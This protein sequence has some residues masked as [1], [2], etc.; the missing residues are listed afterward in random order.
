[1]R[2]AVVGAGEFGRNHAR[3]Y[4]EIPGAELVGIYD[5]NAKRTAEV[6]AEFQAQIFHGLEDLRGRV[7]AVSVA[8]PTVDHANVGCQVD[9]TGIWMCWS[10]SPWP[11]IW[12]KPTRC[13]KLRQKFQRILAGRPCGAI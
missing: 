6:A 13:S 8:V 3:V 1:M 5:K 9:G 4:R 2:V 12:R 7:D 10:R 11:R